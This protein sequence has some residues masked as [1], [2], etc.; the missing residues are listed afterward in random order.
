M[1]TSLPV[2]LL[3]AMSNY[4]DTAYRE[5]VEQR[6]HD[7]PQA[8]AQIALNTLQF[9]IKKYAQDV[10]TQA[11]RLSSD[12]LWESEEL[13]SLNAKLGLRLEDLQEIAKIYKKIVLKKLQCI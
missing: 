7:T 4:W 12:D 3:D 10:K 1:T 8:D 2:E 6:T 5:G 13:M 9:E 11:L